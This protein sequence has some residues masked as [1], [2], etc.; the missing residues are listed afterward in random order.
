MQTMVKL[1]IKILIPTALE[2]TIKYTVFHT[3]D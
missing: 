2:H 1:C 3:F